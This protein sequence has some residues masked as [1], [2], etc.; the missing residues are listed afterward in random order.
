[1]VGLF[2][3]SLVLLSGSLIEFLIDIGGSL[4]ALSIEVER[5]EEKSGGGAPKISQPQ[6]IPNNSHEHI[7][8]R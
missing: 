5:L 3:M 8:N 7:T 4:H 2:L 1:M 6:Y